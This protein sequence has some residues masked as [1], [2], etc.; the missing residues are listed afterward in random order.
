MRLKA[1]RDAAED[2]AYF[3]LLDSLMDRADVVS[4]VSPV[5]Q[6]FTTCKAPAEYATVRKAVPEQILDHL[7]TN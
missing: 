4:M 5:A 2:Y 3:K 1:F 7:K 6:D